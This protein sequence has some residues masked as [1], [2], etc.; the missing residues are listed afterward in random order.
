MLD[1]SLT[2]P[3]LEPGVNLLWAP[4]RSTALHQVALTAL[5]DA[6]GKGIWIDARDTASTSVLNDL[7][8]PRTLSRLRVARSW[9]AYQHHELV[10]Q[11][12]GNVDSRTDLVILPAVASLYEDDDIPSPEDQQYLNS[13]LAILE[14][15]SDALDI[16]I[17]LSTA[18]SSEFCQSVQER[19]GYEIEFEQT[20]LGYSFQAEDFQTQIYWQNGFWQTTIPYW[21]ELLG[22]RGETPEV[23]AYEAGLI[24]AEV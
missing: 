12:P 18:P 6:D 23:A 7:A 17:I 19:A 1:R 20:P 11:L 2:V 9:T 3:E 15:L 5:H 21:V 8:T 13:T 10:R 22:A 24:D 14:H 4:P 16:S